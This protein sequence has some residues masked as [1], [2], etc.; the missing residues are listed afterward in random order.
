M[1]AELLTGWGRTAP[2]ATTVIG[3]PVGATAEQIATLLA[4]PPGPAPERGTIARGL[5]RSYGDAA[6]NAGGV[7]LDTGPLDAF[8]W[9]DAE[10]GVLHAQ[11]GASLGSIL[12]DVVPQG[13]FLPV[14]PGTRHVTVGGALAA[15]IHGK[16]HHADGSFAGYVDRISLATPTGAFAVTAASDPELFWA[17]AGGMGLTGVVVDLTVRLRP[18][19]TSWMR[20]TT[21]RA[22]DL[23]DLLGRMAPDRDRDRYS[24]AWI[25]CMASGKHIGRGVL[26]RGDHAGSGELGRAERRV[27]LGFVGAGRVAVPRWTGGGLLNAATARTFNEAWFRAA[28]P[29]TRL[30][31]LG[32]FF[33]PLDGVAGW[34][35]LYGRRGFVQYQLAVPLAQEAVLA[36][37]LQTLAA[38]R[39]PSFLGVLK[40]FGP[41]DP[42]PLS[43]PTAGWTLA[44]D[45]PARC[46]GLGGVLD[47]FDDLVA[48]AGGRVYLAKDARLKPEL[49][50]SMYPRLEDWRSV[51]RR[52]DPDGRLQ[53]DLGRRLGLAAGG[54]R[55]PTIPVSSAAPASP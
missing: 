2:T 13:W 3:A 42:G 25:D 24:V 10:A 31:G 48:G 26:T 15:D 27:S 8:S 21:E 54:A 23:D 17:T 50:A 38:R 9:A 49:V 12:S 44:L 22:A 20:V 35:R 36:R 30:V 5:G 43:F 29:G 53:S 47:G 28:R 40:R 46:A 16:N 51:C 41:G 4:G 39:I 1:A 37:V 45:L 7:V 32:A 55:V 52:V 14:S 6:Q 11:A 18:I 19:E 33:Y 34:N